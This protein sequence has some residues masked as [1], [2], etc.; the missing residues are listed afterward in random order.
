MSI[1]DEVF[2]RSERESEK[3]LYVGK[4]H[5][6]NNSDIPIGKGLFSGICLK[7][8]DPIC[9]FLGEERPPKEYDERVQRGL[10][11]YAHHLTNYT[12]IDCFNFRTINKYK[13]S[14]TNASRGLFHIVSGRA[15]TNNSDI[16]VDTRRRL[17][18]LVATV[19]IP[20]NT[21]IITSYGGAY[22]LR[23]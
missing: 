23:F 4:S 15:A 2:A 18:R 17:V 10:G 13:A 11:G 21:E 6:R 3:Y 12:I 8:N 22:N 5:Y 19:D 9:T 16:R 7:K 1:R 20:P 14:M